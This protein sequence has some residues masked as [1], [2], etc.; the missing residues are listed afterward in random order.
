MMVSPCGIWALTAIAD[1]YANKTVWNV[2]VYGGDVKWADIAMEKGCP[3]QPP[4]F[5]GGNGGGSDYGCFIATAAYGSRMAEQVQMLRA[6]RDDYL[7]PYAIGQ[8]LVALYYAT[9]KPIAI[10]I[11]S[12][13]WLKGPVRI[14][15]YPVVGL[16]WLFL[17]TTAFAK[18]VIVVCILIGC[19]GVIRFR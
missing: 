4:I 11:D 7:M 14:I 13:P 1:G 17:S 3:D 5:D 9:G 2:A 6:F 18:G 12:H 16:A 8:K 19:V 10:Y 15:L